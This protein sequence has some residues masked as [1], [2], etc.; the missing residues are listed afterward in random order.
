MMLDHLHLSVH[1]WG[2]A[3]SLFGKIL[4][5]IL[6][7]GQTTP[8]FALEMWSKFS[9]VKTLSAKFKQQKTVKSLEMT[10]NS[11][12]SILLKK[13]DFFEWNVVDPRSFSFIFNKDQMEIK[14]NGKVVRSIDSTKMDEK[15]L[16]SITHLRG[17]LTLDEKFIQS[18][19][20]VKK[21]S[22]YRYEFSPLAEKKIFQSILVTTAEA[23]PIKRIQMTEL[24][25]DI[26]DIEFFD[27]KMSNEK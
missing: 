9:H 20:S 5:V 10:L 12:G 1:I 6:L 8:V 23:V 7:L 13:P 2:A 26:I 17:W 27:T 3:M 24:S 18:H 22:Q 4:C 11:R 19:Y 15:L 14:E 16:V 21:I 25:G